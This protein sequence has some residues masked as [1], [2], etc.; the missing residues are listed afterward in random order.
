MILGVSGS[1]LVALTWVTIAR[2]G[3]CLV[4]NTSMVLGLSSCVAYECAPRIDRGRTW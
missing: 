4:N 3:Q 2:A 1:Y